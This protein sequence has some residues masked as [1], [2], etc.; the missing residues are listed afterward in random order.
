MVEGTQLQMVG[1][2]DSMMNKGLE[3]ENNVPGQL[4]VKGWN[5][6]TSNGGLTKG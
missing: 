6:K 4:T 3:K 5:C 2:F 1:V